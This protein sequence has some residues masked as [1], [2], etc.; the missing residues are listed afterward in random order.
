MVFVDEPVGF[1]YWYTVSGR[2]DADSIYADS[3]GVQDY[4]EQLLQSVRSDIG[5]RQCK[6]RHFTFTYIY[7]S[8]STGKILMEQVITPEDY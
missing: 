2:M 4:H 1:N 8:A 5:L 7:R 6:E 3:R